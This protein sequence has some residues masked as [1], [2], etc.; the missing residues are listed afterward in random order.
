MNINQHP[1][2]GISP[3]TIENF[4]YAKTYEMMGPGNTVIHINFR[5]G[6]FCLFPRRMSEYGIPWWE[7]ETTIQQQVNITRYYWL[8]FGIA[9]VRPTY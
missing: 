3:T 5:T 2:R 1:D 4:K 6:K 9:F 7:L 8:T